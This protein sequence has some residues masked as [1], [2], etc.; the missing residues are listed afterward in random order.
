[1]IFPSKVPDSVIHH[2]FS[3]LNNSELCEAASVCRRW[4]RIARDKSLW[5]NVAFQSSSTDSIKEFLGLRA[6]KR[7]QRLYF[8]RCLLSPESYVPVGM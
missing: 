5:I 6:G 1:M 2:V 4:R 8:H 7:I 3:Y